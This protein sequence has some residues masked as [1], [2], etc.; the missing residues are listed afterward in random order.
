M[1]PRRLRRIMRS[2]LDVLRREGLLDAAT[3]GELRALYPTERWDFSSLSR[4]FLIFGAIAF[5]SGVFILGATIF[6]P[7]LP[8]LAILLKKVLLSFCV[9]GF[10][11]LPERTHLPAM[12]VAITSIC[13]QS[14]PSRMLL[15]I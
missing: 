2:E 12:R 5:V 7:T 13:T 3:H 4:W 11:P 8:K 10:P 1:N 14:L 9:T 6:E 15:T